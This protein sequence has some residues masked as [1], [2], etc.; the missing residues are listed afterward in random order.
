MAT[1]KTR[2]KTSSSKTAPAVKIVTAPVEEMVS[3]TEVQPVAAEETAPVKKD[4]KHEAT[5]LIQVRSVTQG[6]LIM[7]GKKSGILYRWSAF[8]D[9]S[10]VEY[11]DLFTMKAVKSKYLYEPLFVI[12]DDELLEDARWQDLKDIYDK[13]YNED[14]DSILNLS[15]TQLEKVLAQ[16]PIGFQRAVRIEVASRIDAGTF[17]SVNKIKVIDRV[18]GSDLM[19]LI[20]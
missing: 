20:S 13:M 19:L 16:M 6:E 4:K 1:T 2:T 11:Q 17:D 15:P 5:E 7:P 14:L 18:C 3:E 9:V 12:E 8:G 10:E